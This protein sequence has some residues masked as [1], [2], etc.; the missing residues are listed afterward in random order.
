MA[1]YVNTFF[2][3]RV[4]KLFSLAAVVERALAAA[5]LEYRVVRGLAV[6]LYVEEREPDAGRRTRDIDI[7][8][9][10]E[11]LAAIAKAV[12]P[13]GLQYRHVAGADM[14][15][16]AGQS[17][18][19]H[20]FPV[21]AAELGEC[22]VLQKIRLIPVE[23]LIRMKLTSCR[24]KDELHL[25]DLDDAG[26]ITPEIQSTLSPIHKQRLQEMRAR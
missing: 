23:D 10:R 8:V 17:R 24:L 11:D 20:M 14:L 22:R 2:E 26:L 7:A 15:V 1:T 21:S 13:F 6:Y 18:A 5:G 9:G 4:E 25:K 16:Q 12:E 3:T 19:V